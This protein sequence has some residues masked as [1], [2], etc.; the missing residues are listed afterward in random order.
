MVY[1]VDEILDFVCDYFIMDYS[2]EKCDPWETLFVILINFGD[3]SFKYIYLILRWLVLF[4]SKYKE[5]RDVF[6][7]CSF[8]VAL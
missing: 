5:W 1:V 8:F 3:I 4:F 7:P 6:D 2:G